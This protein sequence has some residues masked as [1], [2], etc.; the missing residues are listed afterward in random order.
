MSRSSPLKLKRKRIEIAD[1][2]S[3]EGDSGVEEDFG[4]VEEDPLVLQQELN[5]YTVHDE[6][7]E[8]EEAP[9][10]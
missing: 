2:E 6:E 10:D 8:M 3:E 9:V 7:K 4:W 5:G 1:S